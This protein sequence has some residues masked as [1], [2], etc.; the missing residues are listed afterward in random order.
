VKRNVTTN[1]EIFG[2][3]HF[4]LTAPTTISGF[5]P[6]LILEKQVDQGRVFNAKLSRT[7]RGYLSI[8]LRKSDPVLPN[9]TQLN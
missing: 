8:G 1:P 3:T 4:G 6:A 9:F 7:D 2:E 5:P